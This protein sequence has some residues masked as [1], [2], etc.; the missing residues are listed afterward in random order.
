MWEFYLIVSE[1]SFRHGKHMVFQIQM[2]KTVSALS[3]QRD[4]MYE[5]EARL[6]AG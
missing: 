4:Y 2:T 3:I 1:L 6:P 5:N